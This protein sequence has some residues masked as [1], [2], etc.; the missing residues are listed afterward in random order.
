MLMFIYFS[1]RICRCKTEFSKQ[2]FG[3][4]SQVMYSIAR[5]LCGRVFYQSRENIYLL[6]CDNNWVVLA[7]SL[8]PMFNW[9][10]SF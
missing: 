8:S 2:T 4:F 5:L 7:F 9:A 1:F 3:Q 10:G 6:T